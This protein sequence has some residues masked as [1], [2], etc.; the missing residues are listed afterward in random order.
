MNKFELI[1]NDDEIIKIY[2]EISK[3][4]DNQKAWAHHDFRHVD[5]VVNLVEKLLVDMGYD[6]DFVEEAK[7]A[8]LLHDVGC[9]GGKEG[10]ALRGYEYAKEFLKRKNLDLKHEDLILEAI[11]NH[12]DGF[13]TDNVITL[14]LILSDKLDIK[15]TR[16]AKYGYNVIGNRQLQFIKDI[17]IDISNGVF[18]V[19]FI[20]DDNIDKKELEEFYFIPKVFKAIKAFSNKMNLKPEVLFNNEKWEMFYIN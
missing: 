7:I 20:A 16:V 18:H 8:A 12:S 6:K 3:A 15:Y 10:H 1:K 14:A 13:D 9:I 4:E 11:K 17:I 19:S 5:N 2:N